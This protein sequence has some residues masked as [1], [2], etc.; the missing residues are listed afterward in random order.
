MRRK[1]TPKKAGGKLT[2]SETVTVRLD[3]QVRYL[4]E[5]V[6]RK[7]RRTLSSY[8]EWALL[9]CL[10][11]ETLRETGHGNLTEPPVI[12]IADQLW[13]VVE[14][15]RFA[16][17]VF[18]YPELLTHEEQRLWKIMRTSKF[19]WR[20]SGDRDRINKAN[21]IIEHLRNVWDL[22]SGAAKSDGDVFT[23]IMRKVEESWAGDTPG[24]LASSKSSDDAAP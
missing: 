19:L 4:S 11:R 12:K 21:L 7:H 24:P 3:P 9:D 1:K 20:E 8:I 18:S 13:D 6:A 16:N 22:L 23:A 5:L 14:A 2:R 17:L 15:D 10:N